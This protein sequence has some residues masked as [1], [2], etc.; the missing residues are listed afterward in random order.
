M[1]T[2][3][4]LVE[5]RVHCAD[6]KAALSVMKGGTGEKPVVARSAIQMKEAYG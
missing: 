2:F 3:L 4:D 1:T 5:D 6:A